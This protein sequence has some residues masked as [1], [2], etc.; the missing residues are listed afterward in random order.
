MP[1]HN[2]SAKHDKSSRHLEEFNLATAD[3]DVYCYDWRKRN[4]Q[5]AAAERAVH[6]QDVGRMVGGVQ[7]DA[8]RA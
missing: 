8:A 7:G 3:P 2:S 6:G 4:A 1:W 5:E